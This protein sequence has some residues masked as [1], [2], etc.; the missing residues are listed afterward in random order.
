MAQ[1]GYADVLIGL[2]YGDE[3]KARIVDFLAPNYDIIARFNGGANA[4]HTIETKRGKIALNQIPSGVFYEDKTLYIGSGC[5]INFE[6]LSDEVDRLKTFD[7]TVEGRLHISC[8]ASM[9]QPHHV[10]IDAALGKE[11]GTTKNGIGPCYADKAIRMYGSRLANIRVGDLLEDAAA[12]FE[13]AKVNLEESAKM[14]GF[15]AAEGYE[16]LEKLKSGFEKTKQFIEPDPLFIQNRAENGARVLFEGAQSVMLDI[17][18]GAVPFVTSSS[19]VAAAAY[20]GGDLSPAYHRKTIGVAKAIMSRVGHGPFPSEFG[21]RESEEYCMAAEGG[22]PKYNRAI[23]E[24]Y[25]LEK[26]IKSENPFEM[27]QAMR[28]LSRE[29]GTVTARPRRIGVLDLVQLTYAMK[30]NGVT[31]LVINKCDLLKEYSRTA[32]AQIPLVTSYDLDGQTID[33]P[34]G[35][36][37][38]YYRTKPN[39]SY[40]SAFSEDVSAITEY[41]K[42]PQ[43]LKDLLKVIE[44]ET[45]AKVT[46]IGVGPE[47]DQFVNIA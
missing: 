6:K 1:K 10:L 3:G 20:V 28:V 7:I 47:R 43:A 32:K 17:T 36:T 9:I 37:P 12:A 33:Y 30:M 44:Q 24:A 42:L 21:G 26:L 45:N 2:Q 11:V 23:E 14:Y 15:D 29:Y 5:V 19:T 27:G 16:L 25:D 40:Y 35:S 38:T 39:V 13:V 46:G 22:K 18:K 34:P 4:G 41:D 31:E 8:Q